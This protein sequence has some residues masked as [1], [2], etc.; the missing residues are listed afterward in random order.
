MPP[1]KKALAKLFQPSV[2]LKALGGLGTVTV[3]TG[4][5]GLLLAYIDKQAVRIT[6]KPTVESNPAKF[7][8]AALRSGPNFE[9]GPN[10]K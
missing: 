4:L 8:D 9:N 1:I 7:A 3:A 6:T 10:N 2:V 5:S